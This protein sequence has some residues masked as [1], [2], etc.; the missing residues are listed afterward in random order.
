MRL[1]LTQMTLPLPVNASPDEVAKA[2]GEAQKA[3]T[4]V[5]ACSDLHARA[6][7]LK[8]ATSGDLNGV[9]VG[10]LQANQ[11]MF[12]QI[13]KLAVGGTA[14]PF[15]VAEGLQVVA[16]CSKVGARRVADPRRHLPADPAA[17]ARGGGTPV[18]ARPAPPGHDRRQAA[19][20]A[21]A[22]LA[23][24][25]GEPAGIGGELS[26]KAWSMRRAGDRPFFV[27]DDASRLAALAGKLGLNVPVRELDR[28]AEAEHV[29][30]TALPVLPVR[31]RAPV[32]AGQP[33]PANAPAT[34]EAIERAV[35]L[36]LAR[37][38]RRHGDQSH[39]EEDPAG[40]GLPPSRP[41]R[42]SRR[43]GRRRRRRH[44]ARLPRAA[45]RAGHHSPVVG[46]G[47]SRS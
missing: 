32:R 4:G 20:T 33:D 7:E 43:A 13:P 44:D 37:R 41:Y 18:H 42:I 40:R 12:E 9:R 28:P 24:T 45:R 23:V 10:D 6:R 29:F 16:L 36:A 46:R 22:P 26:L 15:R 11:Q 38:G 8:G 47:H 2:T 14:G 1:N 31:L 39:P 27:L 30:A 5:R 25:M 34:L 17:E 3:M 19:M 21:A 35:E